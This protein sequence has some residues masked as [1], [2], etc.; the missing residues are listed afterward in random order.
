MPQ[1][2][3]QAIV[4]ANSTRKDF[5]ADQII[6]RNPQVVG[7]FRLTMKSD[8]DNFRQSATQGIMKRIK[9]KGI[10]VIV[11]EPALN[12]DFFFNSPVEND[13]TKFKSE[14]DIIANVF[15]KLWTMFVIKFYSRLVWI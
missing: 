1:N 7:V 10:K 2:I 4:D 9:A 11:Y 6:K 5:L 15:Q 3:I 14:A 13:L 12:E 8:S